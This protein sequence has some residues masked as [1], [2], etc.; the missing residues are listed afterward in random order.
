MAHA[1]DG[2]VVLSRALI[3][4]HETSEESEDMGDDE[5]SEEE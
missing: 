2:W 5:P 4:P 3:S 1:N